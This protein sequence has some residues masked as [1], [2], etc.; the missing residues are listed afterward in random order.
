MTCAELTRLLADHFAGQL[1]TEVAHA[2]ESHA[3]GCP[4]CRSLFRT[5]GMTVE[6]SRDVADVA[7]PTP[8]A[9]RVRAAVRAL[10]TSG[11]GPQ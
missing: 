6:L 10:A 1:P 4:C 11:E 2:L 9:D 5:Y 3:E 7:V 8:V